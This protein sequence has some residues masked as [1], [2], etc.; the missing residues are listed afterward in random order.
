MF[1]LLFADIARFWHMNIWYSVPAIIAISLVYAGTRHEQMRPLLLHAVRIGAWIVGF[2]FV[3]F[4]VL[5]AI[6]WMI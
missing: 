3:V 5:Q 4:L 1:D 2:M 6:R